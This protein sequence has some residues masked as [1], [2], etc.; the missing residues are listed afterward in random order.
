MSA[1][2]ARG[3]RVCAWQFVY[4]DHPGRRRSGAPQAVRKGADCLVIDAESS[5]EGRYAAADTY[6]DKLRRRIGAKF[7][8]A[9]ASFPYVDYHPGAPLLRLPREGGARFNLPQ[10]YWH[11]I[12]VSVGAAYKHTFIFNRV[13]R[14]PIDPL[15]QTYGNPPM[16]QI[17]RFRRWRSPTAS[18]ES[19]GGTGRR[20]QEGM[21][22]AGQAIDAGRVRRPPAGELPH[23]LQGQPR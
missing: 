3:L 20:R 19:A 10:V 8:T 15:G 22:G 6:V 23:A 13:Y 16:R 7:P 21:A 14:R 9:L 17:K 5:Y 18:T 11:A 1:L 2:R 12:G 4:G